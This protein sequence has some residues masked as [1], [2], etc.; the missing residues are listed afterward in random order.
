MQ[1]PQRRR[2]PW[3]E[4]GVMMFGGGNLLYGALAADRA[5]EY[6]WAVMSAYGGVF[7]I[8]AVQ[9]MRFRRRVDH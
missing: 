3:R 5:H 2:R 7:L 6:W 8:G 4:L 9:L 1:M